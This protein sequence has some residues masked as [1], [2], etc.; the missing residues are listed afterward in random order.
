LKFH[1]IYHF[2]SLET[3]LAVQSKCDQTMRSTKNTFI[4]PFE[5]LENA[6]FVENVPTVEHEIWGFG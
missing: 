4:F 3:E 6:A 2:E 5:A 1:Q